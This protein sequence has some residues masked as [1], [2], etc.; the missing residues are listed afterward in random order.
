[1]SVE[2]HRRHALDALGTI[3]I[4]AAWCGCA[5]TADVT[6]PADILWRDDIQASAEPWGFDGIGVEHPIENEVPPSDANGANLSRVAD[7]AG[8]GGE[9]LRH[10]ATFDAGGSRSQAGIYGDL[11]TAFGDQAKRPEGVW[12]AQ[13]WYFP[14]ALDAGGDQACWINLWDWHS[15][16][17]DRGNRWH[18]SPGL[19]L[20]RDG[21]MK[22]R[23]EWGGPASF[24]PASADSTLA[25]PVGRWFD[26]EMHYRWAD[27]PTATLSLWIDG[28][29][30]LEQRGVQTRAAS[31]ATVETYVKFYGSTQGGTPWTP[32]P[33]IRYTR[34]LRV[35]GERIWR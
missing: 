3:A 20:L 14:R 27:S 13:E 31:H 2:S 15:I 22:V 6:A 12:V 18:T 19:M 5:G 33:S 8:G 30:A 17:A 10:Y 26:V 7:P 25:L 29:L 4:V 11:N 24:N 35:A 21:S 28:Q 32:T 9:A 16:D 23:W 1:M 34:N